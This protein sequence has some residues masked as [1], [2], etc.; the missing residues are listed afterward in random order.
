MVSDNRLREYFYGPKRRE[1]VY[2]LLCSNLVSVGPC[3]R[4]TR[5][6]GVWGLENT[7]ISGSVAFLS[8][9]VVL[10]IILWLITV[11]RDMVSYL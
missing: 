4:V 11:Y 2:V 9:L 5:V 8:R 7:A 1:S 3:M 10:V 6:L